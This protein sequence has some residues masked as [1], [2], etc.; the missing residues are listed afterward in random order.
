MFK[1]R[2]SKSELRDQLNAEVAQFLKKGGEIEQVEMGESALIDGRY[3]QHKSSLDRPSPQER[4]PVHG[5]LSAIDSRRKKKASPS[6]NSTRLKTP[7]EK[8]IY[9]DFGDPVRTIWV[10][11]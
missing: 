11:E 5:L 4:T 7:K 10:D 1:K 8:V 3:N 9:D 2:T 6:K